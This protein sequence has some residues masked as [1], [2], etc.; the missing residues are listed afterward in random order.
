LSIFCILDISEM[1]RIGNSIK[2]F[3]EKM[4]KKCG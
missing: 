4:R 3:S 1:S 2:V